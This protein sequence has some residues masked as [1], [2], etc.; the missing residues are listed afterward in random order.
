MDIVQFKNK[1]QKKIVKEIINDAPSRPKVSVCIQTYQ[2][3]EYIGECLDSILA[4]KTSFEFEILLGD[5]DSNDGGREICNKYARIFPNKIRLFHHHRENNIA[6]DR[7]PTGRFIFMYNLFMA[8]GQF[9]ALCEGDDYWSDPY[10]LQKQ[11]DLLESKT[12]FIA[13]F[14]NA[15]VIE[16]NLESHPYVNHNN[17]TTYSI[18]DII[19]LGGGFYPT[20]SLVFRN[21][22]KNWPEFSFNYRSGDRILSLLL[23]NQGDFYYLD[24]ITCAYRRHSGGVFSSI[25]NKSKIRQKLNYENIKLLKEFNLYTDCKYHKDIKK[26]TSKLAKTGLLRDR[27]LIFNKQTKDALKELNCLDWISF[28]KEIILKK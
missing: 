14:T 24:E 23:A 9:I 2:H 1:F 16:N 17:K 28:L 25:K 12:N 22:I 15:I 8:R 26:S 5:D 11:I 4:Q 13:C 27:S 3:R 6:I 20:A 21:V 18:S 10:K 7:T 19:T